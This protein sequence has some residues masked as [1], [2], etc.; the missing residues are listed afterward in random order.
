[1]ENFK[2]VPKLKEGPLTSFKCQHTCAYIP[3]HAHTFT[4]DYP[5]ASLRHHL[6]LPV[7]T[8]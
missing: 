6:G 5:E 2:H 4:L 3:A 1:M 8:S 7:T